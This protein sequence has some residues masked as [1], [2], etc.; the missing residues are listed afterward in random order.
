MNGE[1]DHADVADNVDDACREP[2]RK[3]VISAV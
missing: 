2:E 1:D 3:L